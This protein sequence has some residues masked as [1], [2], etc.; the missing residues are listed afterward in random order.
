MRRYDA[1]DRMWSALEEWR[2]KKFAYGTADC[3]LFAFS[4]ADAMREDP[5]WLP[6]M[7]KYADYSTF[8]SAIAALGEP[9]LQGRMNEHFGEILPAHRLRQGDLL[10][11]DLKLRDGIQTLC[12]HD[13]TKPVAFEGPGLRAV[14][15]RL[16]IGGWR[17]E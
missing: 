16:I 5:K 4:V 1:A 15:W 11:F 14:P 3:L 2:Q 9:G 17:N 6:E 12:I 13:G 7:Q 8:E 10:L